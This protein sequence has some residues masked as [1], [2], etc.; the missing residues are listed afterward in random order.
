MYAQENGNKR[1]LVIG[2]TGVMGA[3]LVLELLE[4]GYCVDVASRSARSS[5]NP[6]LRYIQVNCMELRALPKVLEGKYDAIID[7]MTYQ[8]FQFAERFESLLAS[9]DHYLFLS[10]YRVYSDLELPTVETSPRL[11]D[12]VE[13][14]EFLQTDDYSIAKA[15]Q[16]NILRGSKYG[17]WT[18]LRPA[19]IYS[20]KRFQLTTLE[21]PQ[22]LRRAAEGKKLL[23]PADAMPVQA[24]MTW[25]G[26]VAKMIARLVLNPK[27]Y[28]EAFSIATAEHHSWGEVAQYY[29]ELIG[30]EYEAVDLD[31]YLGFFGN[32]LTAKFQLKYDR[33]QQR[34]M[35][36]AKL[37]NVTGLKQSELM[38]LRDGLKLELSKVFP[39][40]DWGDSAVYDAMER[41]LNRNA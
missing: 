11:L 13:D 10:S 16:E 39:Q 26:D 2:G 8:T 7:F 27:A 6:K 30:L 33:C 41:Y 29:H 5:E 19:I 38:P 35:D 20:Y 24:T 18:I 31:T 15:R 3:Y 14:A 36:N 40:K 21:A 4:M 25:A 12:A 34:V 37:L 28:R 17:N 22:I 9:T 23:V 32:T 1:V